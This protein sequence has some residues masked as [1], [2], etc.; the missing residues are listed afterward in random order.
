VARSSICCSVSWPKVEKKL[1]GSLIV[2]Y[3]CGSHRAQ[4][5]R[6][7]APY[8]FIVGVLFPGQFHQVL[9]GK[10]AVDLGL[11]IPAPSRYH[12]RVTAAR[13]NRLGS[14]DVGR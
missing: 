1:S 13:M 10:L 3:R 2:A 4:W 11:V 6:A 14:S 9:K 8:R 12:V 5:A 7:I